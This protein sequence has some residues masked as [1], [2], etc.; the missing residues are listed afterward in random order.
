MVSNERNIAGCILGLAIGD[1]MGYTVDS[2]SWEDI[3]SDYGPGGLRGYDLVNG[4]A[5]VSSHTQLAAYTG[6]GLLAGLTRGQMYGRMAPFIRY[7]AQAQKEWSAIQ[8]TRREP[9]RALCWI[10][11]LESLRR[12]RCLDTRLLDLLARDRLGTVHEPLN[13]S[14]SPS[15]LAAAAVVGAF[16]APGRME[17]HE[18][19][20]L[21]AE[22]VALTQGDPHTFLAGAVAA[23]AVAGILQDRDTSLRDHFLQATDTVAAQF[24]REF[25]QA[26]E[27]KKLLHKAVTFVSNTV[28]PPREA[29]HHL[30][31]QT[32]AECLAGAM[33]VALFCEKSFDDAMILAVNHSGR[34]A[35]VGALAGAF[36]GAKLGEGALPDFYLDCLEAADS[37]RELAVD[38]AQGCPL[39]RSARFFDDTWDQKYI[40]GRPVDHA[41]WEA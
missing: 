12:R 28:L 26:G 22:A 36:L 31:C 11:G 1:A 21:G 3:R 16:F 35:A 30:R 37:L 29:L 17:P 18:V 6:C 38:L 32:G 4:Y 39:G 40:Q 27:L 10:S 7:I 15:C 13:A 23:Y 9:A 33:Y 24:G 25:P 5:D 2:R 41:A 14:D 19:G 34:S 20:R 8:H